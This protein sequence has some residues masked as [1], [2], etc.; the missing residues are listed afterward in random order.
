[1]YHQESSA[2]VSQGLIHG[3]R[4]PPPTNPTAPAAAAHS[5]RPTLPGENSPC[6]LLPSPFLQPERRFL[7]Q[8]SL[9]KL[10]S[11]RKSKRVLK[12]PGKPE[13][14]KGH[15]RGCAPGHVTHTPPPPACAPAD[16]ATG[17]FQN[18][19]SSSVHRPTTQEVAGVPERRGPQ[20]AVTPPSPS[21]SLSSPFNC[22][23]GIWQEVS[24]CGPLLKTF[25]P[26]P[27]SEPFENRLHKSCPFT[28]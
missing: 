17:G 27:Q 13:T 16:W 24:H 25:L 19:S 1:M 5:P 15:H 4:T 18:Q 11:H 8:R 7:K 21:H 3:S 10:E 23:F 28:P 14:R 12:T 22:L 6:C 26:P 2:Q 20:P 9:K